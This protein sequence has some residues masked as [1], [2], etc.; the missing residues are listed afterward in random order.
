MR[1]SARLLGLAVLGLAAAGIVLLAVEG[2][3]TLGWLVVGTV[4]ALSAFATFANFGERVRVDEQGIEAT[5][6]L[7]ERLGLARAR[8]AAWADV[9]GAVDQEGD[10]WFVEVKDQRRWVLDRLDGHEE[11]AQIFRDRGIS[12]AARRMPR[13][14]HFG[15][16]R[17]GPP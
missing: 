14:W 10:T 9:L 17:P 6:V 13:P 5:N 3:A 8:R 15:R 2:G 11:L 1:W 12:V 16:D 7:S 4:A